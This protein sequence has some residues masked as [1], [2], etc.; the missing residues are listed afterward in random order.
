MVKESKQVKRNL[1]SNIVSLGIN[2]VIGVLYTP[3][4]V[5]ILGIVAYGVVPLALIINQFISVVTGSLTGALTRFYTIALQKNDKEEASKY[6]S[7]SLIIVFALVILLATPM[8]FIVVNIDKIFNIPY[9]LVKSAKIL[10]SFTLFSFAASLF[11]SVLNITLYAFNRLDYLNVI[12][13]FRILFKFVFVVL[14]FTFLEKDIAYVGIANFISEIAILLFS[15]FI[16]KN[17]TKGTVKINFKLFDK[18]SLTAL[19]IMASWVIVHQLGDTLLYRIDNI[20][21]NRFWSTKESGILGTFTELG[22]YI[23]IIAGVIGSLFGPLI[24][25][26]YG[27][28]DH[29]TVK[30]MTLDRSISVGI[31]VAVVVGIV[32]GFS[33]VILKIWLTEEIATFNIW[34]YIKLILIPFYAAASVFAFANRTW[35]KVKTPAIATLIFGITNF[36]LVW[37]IAKYFNAS[38]YAIPIIL[39]VCSVFGIAQSYFLNGYVFSTLYE[40]TLQSV[41]YDSVKILIVMIAVATIGFYLNPFLLLINPIISILIIGIVAILSLVVSFKLVLTKEQAEAMVSIVYNKK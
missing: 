25:Q 21:V 28:E 31:L 17:F 2:V 35:N 12:K 15:I 24:L 34:L 26:A 6:I 27:R 36:I 7:T 8:Y 29:A 16:F 30:R 11:S 20:I 3:Y 13:I 38:D 5:K 32:A 40:G 1:V 33:P 18:T 39:V 4:L 37:I 19:S 10:F 9:E 14:L 22:S 23:M 41:L